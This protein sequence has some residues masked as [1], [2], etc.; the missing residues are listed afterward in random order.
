MVIKA[1]ASAEISTLVDALVAQDDDVHTEAAIARLA[2]MGPRAVERLIEAYEKMT[3][4]R[5]RIAVLRALEAIG[6]GRAGPVAR[7]AIAEGG[8]VAAAGAGVLRALLASDHEASAADALDALVAAALDRSLDRRVRVAA[9]D[10]LHDVPDVRARVAEAVRGEAGSPLR[11]AA[12]TADRDAARAEAVWNDA[13][14]GRLPDEPA[15]LADTL[16][17]RAATAPLNALRKLIEAVRAKESASGGT[18]W[19]ALRGSLHQ[20]LALRGSRVA[21]YDLRESLERCTAPLPVSFLAALHVLG[22]ASCLEAIAGAW[23]RAGTA[24]ERWRAQLV[25]AFRAI[26]RR[27]KITRRHASAKRIAARWPEAESFWGR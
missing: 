9:F 27:G 16:P 19:L 20:A 26:V 10:A 3:D 21:L 25:A 18:G 12:R 4:R 23:T 24:D 1:S 22:D 17:S 5:A 2:I 6:D 8:D 14:E 13:L 7:G 15:A 11:N